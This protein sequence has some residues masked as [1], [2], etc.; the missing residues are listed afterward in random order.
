M[1]IP[2]NTVELREYIFYMEKIVKKFVLKKN[3]SILVFLSSIS[4][5]ANRE[6]LSITIFSSLMPKLY[7]F[8]RYLIFNDKII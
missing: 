6:E 5:R 4:F 2:R 3:V 7:N 1:L 8:I